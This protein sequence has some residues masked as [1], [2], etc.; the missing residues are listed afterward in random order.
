MLEV[1]LDGEKSIIGA[2]VDAV[3]EVFELDPSEIE[4][5]PRIGR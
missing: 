2:M 4:P 5:A 3:Q 1:N